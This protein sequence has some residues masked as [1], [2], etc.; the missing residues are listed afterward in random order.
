MTQDGVFNA[1]R[2]GQGSATAVID[3]GVCTSPLTVQ[4]TILSKDSLILRAKLIG[5]NLAVKSC[6]LSIQLTTSSGLPVA[7]AQIKISVTGGQSDQN[8]L[9]TD[10]DGLAKDKIIWSAKDAAVTVSAA[11][12]NP[13]IIQRKQ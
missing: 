3:G 10:E 7:G 1:V 2:P 8:Y 5:D 13:T 9:T 4:G 11:G 12:I 6:D